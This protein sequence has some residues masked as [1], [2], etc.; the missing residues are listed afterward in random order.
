MV[1]DTSDGTR[2]CVPSKSSWPSAPCCLIRVILFFFAFCAIF[3]G[4]VVRVGFCVNRSMGG[5]SSTRDD[6]E[7]LEDPWLFFALCFDKTLFVFVLARLRVDVREDVVGEGEGER[8]GA[9]EDACDG[10]CKFCDSN[11][12]FELSNGGDLLKES[13]AWYR[14]GFL[15]TL[16]LRIGAVLAVDE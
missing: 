4:S 7:L 14:V 11:I 5:K 12:E 6:R 2:D 1:T 3:G 10:E 9:A 16:P 8:D 13:A 15:K